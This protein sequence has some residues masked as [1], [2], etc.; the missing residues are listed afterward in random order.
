M[1]RDE[2]RQLDER[3]YVVLESFMNDE[4]LAELRSRIV[5]VFNQE[6]EQA[7]R[8]FR[9]EEHARRLANLV[10][11]GEVFRRAIVLPELL[12]YVRHVL[13]ADIKLSSL[14]ARSADPHTG[15][16]QPL[17][18]DMSA[19]PDE[20]GYWVCNS[21]WMLDDF[22]IENGATRMVPGS[23]RWKQRPQDVLADPLAPHP[24]EVLLTGSAGTIAVM[25]AHLWHGGTANR[26]SKPR[27]AMHAFYC[28]RDKPQQQYQKHL[29]RPEVQAALSPELRDLLALDDPLNDEL[30]ANVTVRSGFLK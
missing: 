2:Q 28:R 23:H 13:G 12:E 1:T 5:A 24:E 19:I 29:L 17:H 7:G 11:K 20:R 22:T 9:T 14:N 16:G 8:E 25:N 21:V 3:G 30:S 18:V 15:V 26:T 6:G 10:D 4:L 27:L